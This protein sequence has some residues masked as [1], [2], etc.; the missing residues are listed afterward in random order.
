MKHGKQNRDRYSHES[1]EPFHPSNFD[2][3]RNHMNCVNQKKS[4]TEETW[5]IVLMMVIFPPVGIPLSWIR[6]KPASKGGRIVLTVF[7]GVILLTAIGTVLG[8]GEESVSRDSESAAQ[9][10][11]SGVESTKGIVGD[12]ESTPIPV[13]KSAL[14]D[15]TVSARAVDLSVYT[16]VSVAVVN[17]AIESA[18]GVL[19]DESATEA[20]VLRVTSDLSSALDGLVLRIDPVTVS[21]V[22]DDVIE[23]PENLRVCLVV[24][25][26]EGNGNFSIWSLDEA[27]ENVDL[28]VN[29]IGYYN[30]RTTTGQ[31]SEEPYYLEISSDGSWTVTLEPIENAPTVQ[32]GVPVVGDD[33]MFLESVDN[34][35]LTFVNEADGNFSVWAYNSLGRDL[36]V[37]DIGAYNGTVPNKEYHLLIVSSE[38]T[39]S[40]SW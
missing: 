18:Q 27:Y 16:D 13:D 19:D 10:S 17:V 21:G 22:G 5:F 40:V 14:E 31:G 23:I 11:E 30:G 2:N 36:L 38:G 33:V 9:I 35:P 7:S 39:W 4:L 8:D 12:E 6:K 3:S 20:D 37:N 26:N 1:N 32:N 34:K 24:A 29:T 15:A 25:V 28:L